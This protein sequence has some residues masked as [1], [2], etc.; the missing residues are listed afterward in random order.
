MEGRKGALR[1]LASAF[2]TVLRGFGLS[3]V[4]L[5]LLVAAIA[6]YAQHRFGPEEARAI[7]ITQLQALLNREVMIEKLV[8]SPRGLKIK[9]LR[10]RR[11]AGAEGDLLVCDTAL[12]TVK[13]APLLDRRLV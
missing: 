9:G 10:V 6:I 4:V 12:V 2:R 3:F 13:L 11:A 5:V 1:L 8:L 7:A